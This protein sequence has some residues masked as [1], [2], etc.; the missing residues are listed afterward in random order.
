MHKHGLPMY[1]HVVALHGLF[2]VQ[3]LQS[4]PR[5]S[6]VAEETGLPVN[7]SR[8]AE[9]EAEEKAEKKEEEEEEEATGWPQRWAG[10][11]LGLRWSCMWLEGSAGVHMVYFNIT[12]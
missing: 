3:D 11:Y 5:L 10:L 2:T 8:A 1:K 4:K 12:V 7:S 9:K 6:Q